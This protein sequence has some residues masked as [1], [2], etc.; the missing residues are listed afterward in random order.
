MAIAHA[1]FLLRL[2]AQH[3]DRGAGRHARLCRHR[4]PFHGAVDGPQHARLHPDGRRGRQLDRRGAVLQARACVP[5]PRR[6]HLQPLRLSRDPRRDRVRRQHHLQDPL[7][8]RGRHDRRPDERR[9]AHGRQIARQVAAEGAKRIVVV[10][11]EPGKYTSKTRMAGG[12]T[13]HHR[14]DLDAVQ[15][16]AGRDS[17]RHGA[18]LR[19]DLRG[20]E[21]P[22]AQARHISRIPTS[23]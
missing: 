10:T 15:T 22:P 20:R 8:R 23:A 5:E 11:D 13:I 7:Q 1:V 6:R 2:P 9:R 19:S 4:L 17:G 3:L 16:R 18:D 21:A 12:I 14:D